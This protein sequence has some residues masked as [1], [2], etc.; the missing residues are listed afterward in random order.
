MKQRAQTQ[1]GVAAGVLRVIAAG[2]RSASDIALPDVGNAQA[3]R[4]RAWNVPF[5]R[6]RALDNLSAIEALG[7]G[8]DRQ[9]VLVRSAHWAERSCPRA[10]SRN[11]SSE[12]GPPH[13]LTAA[14]FIGGSGASQRPLIIATRWHGLN[15]TRHLTTL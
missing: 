10:S 15:L 9:L 6:K 3:D 12:R 13:T 8:L 14:L 4:A 5:L 1:R 7:V 11:T 2:G